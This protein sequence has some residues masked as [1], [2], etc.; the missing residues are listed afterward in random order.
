[1]RS[2]HGLQV[3]HEVHAL[4]ELGIGA[5]AQRMRKEK[6]MRRRRD[7]QHH[8]AAH[9]DFGPKMSNRHIRLS[10]RRSARRCYSSAWAMIVL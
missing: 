5:G 8:L 2:V 7:V 1:M 4:P 6:I 9:R 10:S 3:V